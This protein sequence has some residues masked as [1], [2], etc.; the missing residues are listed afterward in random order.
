MKT[1]R[2]RL[3]LFVLQFCM[4]VESCFLFWHWIKYLF[5]ISYLCLMVTWLLSVKLVLNSNRE[6]A[7]NEMSLVLLLVTVCWSFNIWCVHHSF[8]RVSDIS[9]MRNPWHLLKFFVIH[10][11]PLTTCWFSL[12][13]QILLKNKALWLFW[14][15]YY[16]IKKVQLI[17]SSSL[18]QRVTAPLV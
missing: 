9:H 1:T 17:V 2:W 14:V 7:I 16:G 8:Y 4:T 15:L 12:L 3:S 10:P 13:L 5:F 6:F 11:R 18:L